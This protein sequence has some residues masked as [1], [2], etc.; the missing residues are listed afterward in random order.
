M[1]SG[2]E[3]V[4]SNP[5]IH[6]ANLEM[7]DRIGAALWTLEV[8]EVVDVTPTIRQITFLCRE[9][10][11]LE[12][13]PGNDLT[14]SIA[15]RGDAVVRRRYS[16]RRVDP[17]ARTVDL[18]FV[19]HGDGPAARWAARVEPGDCVEGVGPR[20][21]I[22]VS[23]EAAWHLF[24]AD[25]AFVPAASAMIESLPA[26]ATAYVY[27]EVDGPKD[28][29]PFASS[30]AVAGPGF[31]HREGIDAGRSKVLLDALSSFDPPA[32]VG[33][34]YV[35]GEHALTGEIRRVLVARGIPIDTIATKS[36]WRL[37]I[38]NG[39]HGEPPRGE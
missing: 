28:E 10:E 9:P 17:V 37:G 1:A 13:A 34:V 3:S 25:D 27:F 20:G 33:A 4:A 12:F 26:S 16:I 18:Q 5:E 15:T 36:Y 29:L 23:H 24:V 14:L 35:G 21:K 38:A 32:G 8:S 2:V 22:T 11:S 6:R 7:A 31:L 19:L 39:D 30:A